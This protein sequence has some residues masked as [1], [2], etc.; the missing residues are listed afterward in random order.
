MPIDAGM[1]RSRVTIQQRS[2][3]TDA[4]GQPLTTWTDL[5]TVW[6]DIRTTSGLSSLRA[7]RVVADQMT[8]EAAY[9]VRIRWR[10][11][12]T[13]SMR[14]VETSGGVTRYFDVRQVLEDVAGREYL[15]LVCSLGNGEG[16]T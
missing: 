6:A 4:I 9:S 8:S 3:G 15:D 7:E 12:V 11:D 13:A 16:L 1:L 5:A 2:A 10:A 14:V